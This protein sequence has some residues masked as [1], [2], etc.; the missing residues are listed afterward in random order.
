VDASDVRNEGGT[1]LAFGPF[2]LDARRASLTKAGQ[3]VPLRPKA[4]ALLSYLAAH[5]G[6]V[7]SKTELLGAVWPGVVVT[8][9]SLSQ[10]VREVRAALAD[11]RQQL[12]KTVP[13]RGYL[14]EPAPAIEGSTRRQLVGAGV[15]LAGAL[16][17]S[18]VG[19]TWPRREAPGR[20]AP[21]PQLGPSMAV[22]AFPRP[23]DDEDDRGY[24]AE[25]VA[26]DLINELARLPGT[27][28]MAGASVGAAAA[29]LT[30]V[31][32]LGR[33][34]GVRHFVT[35][36]A[37]RNR[38]S[39]E[40]EARLVSGDSGAVIWSHGFSYSG[41]TDWAWQR[42]IVLQVAHKLGTSLPTGSAPPAQPHGRKLDAIDAGMRGHH[43]LRHARSMFDLLD[44]RLHFDKAL[45]IETGSASTWAGI[46][47]SFL[48]E[49]ENG[50]TTH[51]TASRLALAEPAIDRAL[52]IDPGYFLGHGAKADLL[53][54]R[55]D[56]AGAQAAYLRALALHP[57]EAR[58]H[59]RMGR[60][61]LGLGRPEEVAS[62]TELALRLNPLQPRHVAWCQFVAGMAQFHLGR[63]EAAHGH[64]R[65]AGAADPNLKWA[66]LWLA[67][68]D[69]LEGRGAQASANLRRV[70]GMY[71]IAQIGASW[72]GMYPE[73]L[74]HPRLEPGRARFIEGLRRAG[75]AE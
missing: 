66:W 17:V 61:V 43:L 35:A 24:F 25:G 57:S 51:Y 41:D 19:I 50:W 11:E 29:R 38:V 55:S 6:R 33:E 20:A 42:D 58:A 13:R 26:E 9:D 22:L 7:L 49:V 34:L 65:R 75:L 12:I 47:L 53:L 46:A 59:A 73:A 74:L 69:G 71:P 8:D 2:V 32:E 67:A 5:P 68:I 62:H 44:A 1:G 40:I 16:A 60:V 45:A 10:C 36:R 31:R 18:L 48:A 63:N 15:A 14:F 64:F 23:R 27:L 54:A 39:V 56:F 3:P 52:S 72:K 37:R 70:L 28:V 30:D 21:P 4:L